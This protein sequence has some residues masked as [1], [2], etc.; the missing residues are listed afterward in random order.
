MLLM[1]F[2]GIMLVCIYAAEGDGQWGSIVVGVVL[3][4]LAIGLCCA[5][6]G[7]DRAYHNFRDY[8]KDGGPKR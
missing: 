8:W 5:G 6:R 3:I 4:I 7:N 2:I 1:I